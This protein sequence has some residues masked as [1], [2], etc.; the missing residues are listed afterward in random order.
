[1]WPASDGP[2]ASRSLQAASPFP[3][4]TLYRLVRTLSGR[5]MLSFDP[6]RKTYQLGMR[7]VGLAH[8]AWEQSSLAPIARPH[9]ESLSRAV[10]ETVH[11]AQLDSAH[12]LYVDKMNAESPVAMYSEAGKIGPAYCTGVG[13]VMLA[14]LEEPAL[15]AMLA[16]QSFHR[17]TDTTIVT[18]YDLRDELAAI[19]ARG[20]RGGSRGARTRH[21]LR[22]GADTLAGK[23][24]PRR[25]VGHRSHQPDRPRR[26]A[27]AHSAAPEGVGGDCRGGRSLAFPGRGGRCAAAG[28]ENIDVQGDDRGSRQALRRRTGDPRS[29]PRDRGG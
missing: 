27:R 10:R 22:R 20:V 25:A 16:Q 18:E 4:A 13:K 9:I 15:S 21:H 2:C 11:L 28:R 24:R 3:K 1:M 8:T 19:R 23:K 6:E 7:L 12:V 26:A 29:R 17:F 14:H 5:G